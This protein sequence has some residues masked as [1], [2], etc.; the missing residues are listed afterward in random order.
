MPHIRDS[1]PSSKKGESAAAGQ[2]NFGS[3]CTVWMFN[4]NKLKYLS[5]VYKQLKLKSEVMNFTNKS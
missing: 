1:A 4:R 2:W 3:V 5:G